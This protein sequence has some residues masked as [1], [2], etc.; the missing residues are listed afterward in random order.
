MN[1]DAYSPGAYVFI[2]GYFERDAEHVLAHGDIH[3]DGVGQGAGDV[4]AN[5]Q[6]EAA[7]AA[8]DGGARA[9]SHHADR[10]AGVGTCG[11]RRQSQTQGPSPT[12]CARCK[13]TGFVRRWVWACRPGT[14]V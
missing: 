7:R 12:W 8:D 5:G 9:H 14:P 2:A 6:L 3:G 10:P 13:R 4:E 1:K 11:D